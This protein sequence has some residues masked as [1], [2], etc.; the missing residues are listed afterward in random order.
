MSDCESD[1]GDVD[2]AFQNENVVTDSSSDED[3]TALAPV[4]SPL[5]R[6]TRR[7][8]IKYVIEQ[9]SSDTEATSDEEE[10]KRMSTPLVI[11]NKKLQMWA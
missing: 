7:R 5:Q 10:D 11:K 8:V 4:N 9:D 3:A 1:G 6:C 2:L